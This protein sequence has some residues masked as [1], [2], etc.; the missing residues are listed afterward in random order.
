MGYG[1]AGWKSKGVEGVIVEI[2]EEGR[3]GEG[4]GGVWELV[5]AGW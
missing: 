3:G 2:M 1:T 5:G 4:D